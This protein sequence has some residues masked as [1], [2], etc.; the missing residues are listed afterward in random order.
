MDINSRNTIFLPVVVPAQLDNLMLNSQT[1]EFKENSLNDNNKPI[2]PS[3]NVVNYNTS[4]TPQMDY[5]INKSIID[6][7][8]L[9]LQQMK[10]C[11]K[12]IES[13]VLLPIVPSSGACTDTTSISALTATTTPPLVPYKVTNSADTLS[14]ALSPFYSLPSPPSSSSLIQRKQMYSTSLYDDDIKNK[15]IVGL[16]QSTS[17][18]PNIIG[19]N[20]TISESDNNSF[21]NVN[22]SGII[23]TDD[24]EIIQQMAG[25]NNIINKSGIYGNSCRPTTEMIQPVASGN[26]IIA[27][28]ITNTTQS[29]SLPLTTEKSSTIQPHTFAATTVLPVSSIIVEG[30]GG[31]GG[32]EGVSN[33]INNTVYPQ[34]YSMNIGQR[35]YQSQ[36]QQQNQQHN[37]ILPIQSN[38]IY[39]NPYN[40]IPNC[41]NYNQMGIQHRPNNYVVDGNLT[42]YIANNDGSCSNTGIFEKENTISNPNQSLYDEQKYKNLCIQLQQQKQLQQQQQYDKNLRHKFQDNNY[43]TIYPQPQWSSYSLD[44]ERINMNIKEKNDLILKQDLLIQQQQNILMN[45]DLLYYNLLGPKSLE[46]KHQEQYQTQQQQQQNKPST[47]YF[48]PLENNM[49]PQMSSNENTGGCRNVLN[50]YSSPPLPPPPS[51]VKKLIKKGITSSSSVVKESTSSSSILTVLQEQQKEEFLQKQ[52][53]CCL[54]FSPRD[55][56]CSSSLSTTSSSSSSLSSTTTSID[57]E[58]AKL[59]GN[60]QDDEGEQENDKNVEKLE[61]EKED[62]V[63]PTVLVEKDKVKEENKYITVCKKKKKNNKNK[64]TSKVV[65]SVENNGKSVKIIKEEFPALDTANSLKSSTNSD[66]IEMA[67]KSNEVKI[68][69]NKSSTMSKATTT[70]T[71]TVTTTTT[72]GTSK[73][74]SVNTTTKNDKQSIVAITNSGQTGVLKKTSS[75]DVNNVNGG[76]AK[77]TDK[78]IRF[79]WKEK[80]VG[81]LMSKKSIKIIFLEIYVLSS[82][83]LQVAASTINTALDLSGVPYNCKTWKNES[84]KQLSSTFLK[85]QIFLSMFSKYSTNDVPIT[86]YKLLRYIILNCPSIPMIT[87][88]NFGELYSNKKDKFLNSIVCFENFGKQC[89]KCDTYAGIIVNKKNTST[90]HLLCMHHGLEYMVQY[91]DNQNNTNEYTIRLYHPYFVSISA[92]IDRVTVSSYNMDNSINHHSTDNQIKNRCIEWSPLFRFNVPKS[93]EKETLNNSTY[94]TTRVSYLNHARKSI[95]NCS[96]GEY[97]NAHNSQSMAALYSSKCLLQALADQPYEIVGDVPPSEEDLPFFWN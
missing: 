67:N 68:K 61:K 70:T 51:E 45:G 89:N 7:Q 55:T 17:C 92:T 97:T 13:P 49:I 42:T 75:S 52:K 78:E 87:S 10:S 65:E 53:D 14:A 11:M 35:Q 23:Y 69:T 33:H 96:H 80:V 66:K 19:Y 6:E 47:G 26:N 44:Q 71:T 94:F 41:N 36:Q 86:P 63:E 95:I 84:Y 72:S 90:K 32:G 5:Y 62:C 25:S 74:N 28:N 58:V 81:S 12:N 57:N 76:V 48:T 15:T 40:N 38:E 16:G 31:G 29:F 46:Y 22:K 59:C 37:N 1:D 79:E 83:V 39:K 9:R 24:T 82:V 8:I 93:I 20:N 91:I 30:N 73:N 27:N 2:L 34:N 56:V 4:Q 60:G 3:T 77:K 85:K 54:S 88:S 50:Y 18:I 21:Y 43:S 64:S